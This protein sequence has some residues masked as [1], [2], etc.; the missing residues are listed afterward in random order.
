M[1]RTFF[2]ILTKLLDC[3]VVTLF[4]RTRILKWPIQWLHLDGFS[5]FRELG[6]VVTVAFFVGSKRSTS[7]TCNSPWP[8]GTAAATAEAVAIAIGPKASRTATT[9]ILGHER[10][11]VLFSLHVSSIV[12]RVTLVLIIF[13]ERFQV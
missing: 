7:L 10:L 13:L 5:M 8:G 2:N 9:T 6:M 12:I 3:L 11:G 1:V 4:G